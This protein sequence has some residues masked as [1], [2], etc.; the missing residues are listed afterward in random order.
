MG[1]KIT[2]HKNI[3]RNTTKKNFVTMKIK[4]LKKMIEI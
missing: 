3:A 2:R 1:V 4:R